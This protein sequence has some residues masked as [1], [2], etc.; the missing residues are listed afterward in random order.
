MYTMQVV[1]FENAEKD[2]YNEDQV[3][4]Y[5][6]EPGPKTSLLEFISKELHRTK[7][8][9]LVPMEMSDVMLNFMVNNVRHYPH[10]ASRD[11]IF[12]LF[13][14]YHWLTYKE[15]T[16]VYP[17]FDYVR[18]ND[19]DDLLGDIVF[20]KTCLFLCM[21]YKRIRVMLPSFRNFVLFIVITNIAIFLSILA[22]NHLN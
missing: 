12:V 21:V 11:F 19:F 13:C 16:K 8:K 15:F 5:L 10:E 3:Y 17:F 22:W 1:V 7:T 9:N 20:L 4:A 18:Q 2:G 14:D 6:I